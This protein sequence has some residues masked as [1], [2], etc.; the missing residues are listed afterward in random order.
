MRVNKMKVTAQ[1][2]E[3]FKLGLADRLAGRP[4]IAHDSCGD[5]EPSDAYAI[6]YDPFDEM[7]LTL[8]E[9][10]DVVRAFAGECVRQIPGGVPVNMPRNYITRWASS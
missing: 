9:Y 3:C 1:L 6:G 8:P 4:M 5:G 2:L 10:R 7:S